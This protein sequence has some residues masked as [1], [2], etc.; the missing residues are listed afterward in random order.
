MAFKLLIA[1]LFI[2]SLY[3]ICIHRYQQKFLDGMAIV[4][5]HGKPHLFLTFT[6]FG[7][8]DQNIKSLFDDN[9][10]RTDDR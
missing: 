10:E 7:K 3:N 4:R 8:W 9:G 1:K 5:E 6:A 2:F